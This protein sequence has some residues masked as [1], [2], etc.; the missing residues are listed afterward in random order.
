MRFL[1]IMQDW[2]HG[3]DTKQLPP[4]PKKAPQTAI[5]NPKGSFEI[6]RWVSAR[7]P[8]QRVW[9]HRDP[10][11]GLEIGP[12]D[13]L[14]V[15]N[16]TNPG[17][18]LIGGIRPNTC[19]HAMNDLSLRHKGNVHETSLGWCFMMG[20]FQVNRMKESLLQC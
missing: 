20:L 15:R 16:Q 18:G 10:Q 11:E 13:V 19:W 7:Y 4:I 1:V 6:I 8:N 12:G 14:V 9:T 2:L 5:N 3:W 17:H